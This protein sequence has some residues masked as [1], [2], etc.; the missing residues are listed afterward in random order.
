MC[1]SVVISFIMPTKTEDNDMVD[2]HSSQSTWLMSLIKVNYISDSSSQVFAAVAF[3]VLLFLLVN[4]YSIQCLD[5][6]A[7]QLQLSTKTKTVIHRLPF[8]CMTFT[9]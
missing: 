1:I 5:L 2:Y 8:S 4:I 7:A 3:S 9:Q 6:Q